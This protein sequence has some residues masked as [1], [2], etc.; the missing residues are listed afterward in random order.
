MG[1]GLST[2][3]SP[4]SASECAASTYDDKHNQDDKQDGA[5]LKRRALLVGISYTSPHNTWSPLDGP[6][7]DV[8][9]YQELLTSA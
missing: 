4:S 8:D 3:L 5:S 2:I 6:Y 7:G 9:R 1:S